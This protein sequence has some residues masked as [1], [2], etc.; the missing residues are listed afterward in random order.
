MRI[1]TIAL[2]IPVIA[3]FVQPTGAWADEDPIVRD[4]RAMVLA[5]GRDDLLN[6][7]ILLRRGY[8]VADGYMDDATLEN[9]YF[10]DV[11]LKAGAIKSAPFLVQKGATSL[12]IGP[13]DCGQPDEVV[14]QI[15]QLL[16]L[17][18]WHGQDR[19]HRT[20]LVS[21]LLGKGIGDLV[22]RQYG[23]GPT[24]G[25]HLEPI[26]DCTYR[27]PLSFSVIS[28][29]S[30]LKGPSGLY[31]PPENVAF[32]NLLVAN[33]LDVKAKDSIGL[34]L[35]HT[36]IGGIG[37]SSLPLPEL[38][39]NLEML[40]T[41]GAPLDEP[42]NRGIRPIDFLKIGHLANTGFCTNIAAFVPNLK[43]RQDI[44]VGM[45]AKPSDKV[46][47]TCPTTNVYCIPC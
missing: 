9:V 7:T 8:I 47:P 31:M 4:G 27:I 19:A 10:L 42:D 30:Y 1:V 16:T 32:F 17:N 26:S 20:S 14:P 12:A 25:S 11:A 2:L 38:K 21:L 46:F 22:D 28:S 15:L 29:G 41:A 34:S 37:N 36:Y 40:R 35:A 45:G 39:N 18:S 5:L 33:G 44:L 6:V 13:G 24:K 23:Y 3:Q 43:E